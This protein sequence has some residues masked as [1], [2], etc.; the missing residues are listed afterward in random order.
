M[1]FKIIDNII[2]IVSYKENTVS[3]VSEAY[4]HM[5]TTKLVRVLLIFVII[6]YIFAKYSYIINLLQIITDTNY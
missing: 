1:Y 3:L 2:V 6:D 5:Y 4:K